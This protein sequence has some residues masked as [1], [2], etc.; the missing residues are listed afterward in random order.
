MI[1]C[2]Q[3]DFTAHFGLTGTYTVVHYTA[4]GNVV[5]HDDKACEDCKKVNKQQCDNATDEQNFLLFSDSDFEVVQ[6]EK[7][8]NQFNGKRAGLSNRCDLML[9]SDDKIAFV[10]MYC[11]QQKFIYSYINQKGLQEGKL[12]K[13]RKQITNV[14]EK[15]CEVPS[16]HL[17][18]LLYHK[19]TGVFACR[20]KQPVGEGT[21]DEENMQVF[22]NTTAETDT[23][24]LLT[25]GF[26]FVVVDYPDVYAW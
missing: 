23:H 8:F 18:L 7:Y 3:N 1:D 14:I 22:I 16:I 4:Q 6:I 13:A 12:A 25:N 26:E 21:L 9:F 24:T 10:D 2:L 20:K 17:K 15:L 11:G 19:K 5:F